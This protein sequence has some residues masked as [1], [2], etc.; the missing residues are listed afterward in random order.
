[1]APEMIENPTKG[2]HQIYLVGL[3]QTTVLKCL[4]ASP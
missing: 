2:R 1:L 4:E 3:L